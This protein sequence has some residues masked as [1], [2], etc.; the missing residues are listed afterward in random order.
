MY[1]RPLSPQPIQRLV[2]LDVYRGLTMFLLVAEAALVYDA[3]LE[4]FSEEHSLHRLFFTI[5][6]SSMEWTALLGFDSAL[7][8]VYRGE[9]DAFFAK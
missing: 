3:L 1:M 6:P 7:F 5:H 9:S 8:H 2:S 4:M